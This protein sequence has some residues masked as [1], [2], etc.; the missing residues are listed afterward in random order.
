MDNNSLAEVSCY[1][2]LVEIINYQSFVL[3]WKTC[4]RSVRS[5][6]QGA[7]LLVDS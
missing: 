4:E 3:P 1:K 6:L 5:P 2:P 7:Y